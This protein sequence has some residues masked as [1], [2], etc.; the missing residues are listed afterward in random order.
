MLKEKR[1]TIVQMLNELGVAFD[2]DKETKRLQLLLYRVRL[3]RLVAGIS[4]ARVVKTLRSLKQKPNKNLDRQGPQLVDY[5][6]RHPEKQLEVTAALLSEGGQDVPTAPVQHSKQPAQGSSRAT[7][8]KEPCESGTAVGASLSY[9]EPLPINSWAKRRFEEGLR[10]ATDERVLEVLTAESL[11][12][13]EGL[14]IR[15]ILRRHVV[16]ANLDPALIERLSQELIASTTSLKGRSA[17][18]SAAG[19]K[20]Y[21]EAASGRAGMSAAGTSRGD[22]QGCNIEA[23]VVRQQKT[24][25][26]AVSGRGCV[27]A[28]GDSRMQPGALEAAVAPVPNPAAVARLRTLNLHV[29][30]LDNFQKNN[31]Y[32]NTVLTMLINLPEIRALV[33]EEREENL[34]PVSKELQRLM[35][36]PKGTR[37]SLQRLRSLVADSLRRRPEE[38]IVQDYD[39]PRQHDASEFLSTVIQ[40][41]IDE[42]KSSVNSTVALHQH[43]DG[44]LRVSRKCL[45]CGN[46]RYCL[47]ALVNPLTLALNPDWEEWILED[48]VNFSVTSRKMRMEMHCPACDLHTAPHEEITEYHRLP[49]IL[50]VSVGRFE[51]RIVGTYDGRNTWET[52]KIKDPVAVSKDVRVRSSDGQIVEYS[53]VSFINH[54]GEEARSGHYTV[55]LRDPDTKLFAKCDDARGFL[56]ATDTGMDHAPDANEAY[57]FGFV[58]K[59]GSE[60]LLQ[61]PPRKRLNSRSHE[62]Y[63]PVQGVKVGASGSGGTSRQQ[64]SSRGRA[65]Q[66]KVNAIPP[67]NCS[68]RQTIGSR[69]K[70]S[71]A[72]SKQQ[73]SSGGISSHNA[74]Q[75]EPFTEASISGMSRADILK[76]LGSKSRNAL[77]KL[78][79]Q[80]LKASIT[81]FVEKMSEEK[82]KAVVVQLKLPRYSR[83]KARCRG[84]IVRHYLE[85]GNQQDQIRAMLLA[86]KEQAAEPTNGDEQAPEAMEVSGDEVDAEENSAAGGAQQHSRDHA[87]DPDV[88]EIATFPNNFYPDEKLAQTMQTNFDQLRDYRAERLARVNAGNS[89]L[90]DMP[91]NPILE[92]GYVMHEK[93]A[94]TAWQTCKHCNE[95]AL[96]MKLAPRTKK[97][98]KCQKARRHRGKRLEQDDDEPPVVIPPMFSAENDMHARMPPP[99]IACL[100]EVEQLCVTRLHIK[101]SVYRLYGRSVRHKG[102]CITFTHDLDEF[103]GRLTSLPPRPADLP[104]LIVAPGDETSVGLPANRHKILQALVWLKRNNRFYTDVII[105]EEVLRLYPEDDTTPVAG[106]H[107]VRGDNADEE[108][109]DNASAYT[110]EEERAEMTYSTVLTR[111]NRNTEQEVIE[112]EVLRRPVRTA[113]PNRSKDPVSEWTEGYFSMAFPTLPGFCYGECDLTV[114]RVGAQPSLKA[115]VKHLLAHPSRQF[116]THP[117]F[118]L[119]MG[120]RLLRTTALSTASIYAKLL[121]PNMTMA[122]LKAKLAAGDATLISKLLTF[123]RNVPGTRQFWNWK[124]NQAYSLVDW[125]HLMSD[126]TETFTLFLTLSFADNHILELHRLLDTENR[127]IDK[128]VVNNASEIPAEANRE[129]YITLAQQNKMRVEAV[130]SQPDVASEFLNKK[131]N[132]LLEHVLVPCLGALDWIIRCEFQ[133]RSTEH[134]HMVLRLKDGPSIDTV[135]MA[136]TTY[137]FDVKDAVVVPNGREPSPEVVAEA[138]A[139]IIDMGINRIGLVA[140]HPELDANNWPQPEGLRSGRPATNCLRMTFEEAMLQPL[141]DLIDLYNRIM[142]HACNKGYCR[143]VDEKGKQLPCNQHFPRL[144]VGYEDHSTEEVKRLVRCLEVA[145]LGA[146]F[147]GGEL[148]LL[149]NHPRVVSCI[150]EILQAWRANNDAQLIESTEQLIAYILKYVMKPEVGSVAFIDSVQKVAADTDE[151]TPVRKYLSKVLMMTVNEHDYSKQECVRLFSEHPLV[152]MSRPFVSINVVGTRRVDTGD[153]GEEEDDSRP[154]TKPTR[155]DAYWARFEDPNFHELIGHYEAGEVELPRHPAQLS[156]YQAASIFKENWQ[157]WNELHVP[158]CTPMFW[159]VPKPTKPEQRAKYLRTMLLLHNPDCRPTDLPEDLPSLEA[160][161]AAFVSGPLC[162]LKVRIDYTESLK[163]ERPEVPANERGEL[164]PAPANRPTGPVEQDDLMLLMGGVVNQEDINTA[165]PDELAMHDADLDVDEENLVTDVDHNWQEDGQTLGLDNASIQAAAG[166]LNQQKTTVDIPQDWSV[167]YNP[168]DLNPEQR[169]AFDH[170]MGLVRGQTPPPFSPNRHHKLIHILGEAGTG[171]SQVIKTAQKCA[172][173]E[174]GNGQV[175]RVAAYTNSAANHFTGGQTLHRLFKIDVSKTDTFKYRALEGSRLAELQRD[176]RD[177]VILF[178]D[179]VSFV[180]QSMLYAVHMRCCQA[181]PHCNG[182]LFGGIA[183]VLCGDPT[184]LPA[185]G[186]AALYCKPGPTVEQAQGWKLYQSFD[187]NFVLTRSMRQDGAANAEFRAQLKRLAT[188]RFRRTDWV[189]WSLR[190]YDRLSK[191]ER[192]LFYETATLLCARKK[193]SV[194]FN[195]DGLRRTEQPLLA[196]RADHEGGSKASKFSANQAGGLPKSLPI[197]KGARI[198]LTANLWADAGLVNGA[199]GTVEYIVFNEGAAPPRVNL[200]AMLICRFPTYKG[201]SFLPEI[202]DCLVPVFPVR[203]DWMSGKVSYS[204]TM[205]PLLL[206]YSMTIHKSQGVTMQ[207]VMINVGDREFACGLT[208]TGVSRVRSLT[209]LAFYPFPNF[210]RIA[211]LR[212]H[213]NF[214]QLRKEIVKREQA[215]V[216]LAA[217]LDELQEEEEEELL[218]SQLSDLNMEVHPA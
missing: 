147:V 140:N 209:D 124:R 122:E 179:E 82:V 95:K 160:D 168:D 85:N 73:T 25:A 1:D 75:E 126:N 192:N 203:R 6:C 45:N 33:E 48:L 211:R 174:T 131:L 194:V 47:E 111:D 117:T 32:A 103:S 183:V 21:A 148:Q 86:S 14:T 57:I 101:M 185:P 175:I 129:D 171:K 3:E 217:E 208:Y 104:L 72:A 15:Q 30:S 83:E 96:D 28:A 67:D 170:I 218:S 50:F 92:A 182:E 115:W 161:M 157:P 11:E 162:P 132:L 94:A 206:A 54:N 143:K 159:Y 113:M 17:P 20:T 87:P 135:K 8:D 53:L 110:H 121:D 212:T 205:F 22:M 107:T 193:D 42:L 154:S 24:F 70:A 36:L 106:L 71:E 118:L 105:D 10:N 158:Y 155:A 125:V 176:L 152:I 56:Q 196:M 108:K 37:Q 112:Q 80:L 43:L 198:I 100:N 202:S 49:T 77:H 9:L 169:R 165:D 68:K 5:L 178:I 65:A 31:C 90:D 130:A 99:E 51:S 4:P 18:V 116:V 200:P 181:R 214:I 34:G 166:W 66:E 136:F 52:L 44:E 55:S 97:C 69:N 187:T 61:S 134:F 146:R 35:R 89:S 141:Q 216:A 64:P 81:S 184:Q 27:G 59:T 76:C 29:L 2:R 16:A 142:L 79:T 23:S 26:E 210:D 215:A 173:D 98:Q 114:A 40:C 150:Q 163:K 60:L 164:N 120:N 88:P 123:C 13:I 190:C 102:H 201:P 144:Q 153:G 197:T 189:A 180:S 145:L 91:P 207:R 191:E 172:Y 177:C 138:R 127:Y 93:L 133:H 46:S 7:A 156:L 38:E 137:S 204:R 109:V 12:L 41:L 74:S 199:Q 84:A 78:R 195:L 119:V 139:N 167:E 213:N 58:K 128:I 19:Q 151:N 149:R 186:D 39:A 188:G 62:V 63:S